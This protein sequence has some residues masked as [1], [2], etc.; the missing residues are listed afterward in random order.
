VRQAPLVCPEI[1]FGMREDV[2]AA[3]HSRP[4]ESSAEKKA[5]TI[6][7]R[8]R[9]KSDAERRKRA[10][11][12]ENCHATA[13][14]EEV[15][16]KSKRIKDGY[17]YEQWCKWYLRFHG[18]HFVKVTPK[19]RDFGA[20]IICRDWLFR[21]VVVQCKRYKNAVGIDAVQQVAAARSYYRAWYGIVMT[22]ADFTKSARTLAK[23][24]NVKLYQRKGR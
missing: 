9:T 19:S 21:K 6:R 1:L 20:D 17:R 10:A 2:R 12:T 15:K 24:C 11:Q 23:R 22:N 7:S 14:G 16:R 13:G 4:P 3:E 18:F 8:A 5:R